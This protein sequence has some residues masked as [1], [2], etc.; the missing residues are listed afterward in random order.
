MPRYHQINMINTHLC[1]KHCSIACFPVEFRQHVWISIESVS[2]NCDGI[3]NINTYLSCSRPFCTP[4]VQI[5]MNMRDPIND[6][7]GIDV[8]SKWGNGG[9]G[10]S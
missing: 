6:F 7:N 5:H 4:M 2:W 1:N 8:M 3:D 10:E 9:M